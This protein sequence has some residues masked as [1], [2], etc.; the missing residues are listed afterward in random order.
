MRSP[1]LLSFVALLAMLVG[2][3]SS[4]RGVQAMPAH[5]AA[6]STQVHALSAPQSSMPDSLLPFL[7]PADLAIRQALGD[8]TDLSLFN[9][10]EPARLQPFSP[11]RLLSVN[12]PDPRIDL[13]RP[14]DPLANINS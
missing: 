9:Q 5:L 6:L 4:A 1:K 13:P 12:L 8:S 7:D 3:F 2:L 11:N 10:S 14:P